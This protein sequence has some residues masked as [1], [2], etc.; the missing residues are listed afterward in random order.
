MENKRR[1]YEEKLDAQLAELAAQIRLFKAKAA[2][3]KAEAKVEYYRAI[4]A[5]Q[6]KQS[7]A[8][9]KLRQMKS[10]GNEAWDDFKSGAEKA[11]ED[12]MK[13]YDDA[14]SRFK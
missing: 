8:S 1:A 12:M 11:W 3:S 5:L 2:T 9:A 10:A 6:L 4:D 7:E 14:R 13:A